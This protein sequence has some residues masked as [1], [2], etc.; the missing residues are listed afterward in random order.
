MRITLETKIIVITILLL[1]FFCLGSAFAQV[2][3]PEFFH[4]LFETYQN[5]Y[6]A[7][8]ESEYK[9]FCR[10]L[11]LAEA[12]TTNM[13]AFLTVRFFH[14]LFTGC[15]AVDC[16]RGGILR[17]P[18]FWHW[19]DP[20]PR[21]SIVFLPDSVALSTVSPPPEYARYKSHA[22]IDRV[23]VLFIGDLVRKSPQYFHSGCG[24]FYTFGWCSEREMAFVAIIGEMGFKGKI[25][26]DGIHTWS[27]IRFECRIR[28]GSFRPVVA[29][30]DNTFDTI[31]WEA[32]RTDASMEEWLRD[33]GSGTH[34]AWYNRKARSRGQIEK[35]NE[36]RVPDRAAERITNL[37]SGYIKDKV[38]DTRK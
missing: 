35:L 13:R 6:R 34:I 28:D 4:D 8:R 24:S 16:V 30:V 19:T 15:G 18:Y 1:Q 31:R 3:I 33:V 7:L 21:H 5:D 2:T 20:N 10:S 29:V 17:I 38:S 26:Q 14:D 25:L 9:S 22:D 37:V 27:E 12:D 23:P 11:D 36:M 32:L